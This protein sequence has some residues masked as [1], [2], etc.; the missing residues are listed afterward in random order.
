MENFTEKERNKIDNMHAREF[1]NLTSDEVQLLLR[2]NAYITENRV[3]DSEEE[4]R[5]NEYD[6]EQL[7]ILKREAEA[8][9]TILQYKRDAAREK[10]ERV[11]ATNIEE[12]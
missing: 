4:K 8:T 3:K 11:K 1:K 2:W 7:E 6:K 5:R 12:V 9:K 10:L